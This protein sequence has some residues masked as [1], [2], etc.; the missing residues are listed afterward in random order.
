MAAYMAL[1]IFSFSLSNLAFQDLQRKTS[2]RHGQTPRV[3]VR[4]ANQF[5]GPENDQVTVSGMIIPG[6]LG[7]LQALQDL[8]DMGDTG[9][10]WPLVTGYGDVWGAFVIDSVSEGQ[11]IFLDDGRPRKADFTAELHRVDDDDARDKLL[12]VGFKVRR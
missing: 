4:P 3:G 9:S 8:R 5:M 12:P 6:V 7:R 2:W 10:A 1:G 11:Q